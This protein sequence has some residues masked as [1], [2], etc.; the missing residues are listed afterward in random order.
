M[1]KT[2]QAH[3]INGPTCS[4]NGIPLDGNDDYID[5]DDFEFGGITSFEVYIKYNSFN[6]LL[7]GLVLAPEMRTGSYATFL[8]SSR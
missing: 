4:S 2:L 5:I 8:G 7:R 3:P 6:F 1:R